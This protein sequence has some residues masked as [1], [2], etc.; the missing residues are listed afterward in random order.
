MKTLDPK[1]K[2]A[3]LLLRMHLN[4]GYS[5]GPEFPGATIRKGID[6]L[7]ALGHLEND[8]NDRMAITKSGH[9]YLKENHLQIT[10]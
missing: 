2:A 6:K 9:Q 10:M 3:T 7:F 8:A 4:I 5:A 1:S